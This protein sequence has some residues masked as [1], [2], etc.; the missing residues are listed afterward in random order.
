MPFINIDLLLWQVLAIQLTKLAKTAFFS[1][2]SFKLGF[3]RKLRELKSKAL[4]ASQMLDYE[5]QQQ[6]SLN[7]HLKSLRLPID[8]K[9]VVMRVKLVREN[10]HKLKSSLETIEA[11]Q[12]RYAELAALRDKEGKLMIKLKLAQIRLANQ[13]REQLQLLTKLAIQA[14]I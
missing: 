10:L 7:K 9:R 12:G 11:G 2:F 14:Y 8:N 4:K 1:S 3:K 5:E 13:F 6:N